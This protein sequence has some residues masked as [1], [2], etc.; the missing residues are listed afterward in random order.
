MAEIKIVGNVTSFNKVNRFRLNDI[1]LIGVQ[2]LSNTFNPKTDYIEYVIYDIAGNFIT[3]DYNY[4]NF[5]NTTT[6]GLNPN[7]SYSYLEINPE[8]DIQT[9]YNVG[10]FTTQYNFF[11][12]KIGNPQ[13]ADLFIKEISPDRTELKISTLQLSNLELQ[14]QVNNLIDDKN[15][16]PYLKSYLLN[17]RNNNNLLITNIALDTTNPNEYYVLF[18]LYSPLPLNISEKDK[19]WVVEEISNSLQFNLNIQA[20][21]IPDPLPQLKGPNFDIEI[22][23]K[24]TLPTQ[25]ESYSTLLQFTGSSLHAILNYLDQTSIDINVDYTDFTNFVRFGSAQ[26]RIENFYYK[27]KQIELYNNFINAN[28][29]GISTTTGLQQQLNSYSASVNDIISKFDGF[30]SYLYFQTGSNTYPHLNSI[31]P[32]TQYASTSTEALTWYT[33]QTNTAI[34]YDNNNQDNL[35]YLI[36]EYIRIDSDNVPYLTFVNMIGQYF[37][38]IYIYLKSVTDLYKS[39]N[40]LEEGVSKDLVYYA[41]Q[42]LGV[43]IYNSNED[44]NL[45]TYAIAVSGSNVPSK[46]LV[47]ELYKRIYHNIPLLF[48]GKGSRRGM[49]ELITTFGI[50]GSILGIKEY[51]GDTNTHASLVDYSNNKVRVVNN[52]IYSSSYNG[53][54]GSI[55]SPLIKLAT[56]NTYTDYKNDSDRVDI[57]FSPYNQ[58]DSTIS[59]SIAST[60]PTFNIDDFIGD[61]RNASQTEYGTLNSIRKT[62]IDSSFTFKYDINGFI[63]LIKFFDNTLFKML[64]SYIPAKANLNEGITIRQQALERIKFKRNE[65]N[66]AEQTVYDAEYSSPEIT[67]DNTY[68]YNNLAGNKAAF[69]TG[70]ISGSYINIGED[71]A[72]Q[73]NPYLFPTE[74]INKYEFNHTDY[75][76]LLNNIS[77]NRLSLDRLKIEVQPYTSSNLLLPVE[78]QDSY[79]SLTSYQLSRHGGIKLSSLKYNTYTPKSTTYAGDTSYGQSAVIDRYSEK[80]GLFTEI[81]TS[82]VFPTRL[83]ARLKYLVDKNGNLT[84]LNINNKHWTD[85]QNYFILNN[86]STV[87][88]FNDQQYSNQKSTNGLKPIFNSGYSYYPILYYSS[89]IDINLYFEYSSNASNLIFTAINTP[90]F[91]SSS[92]LVNYPIITGSIYNAF[93]NI[94]SN[95]GE[96]YKVGTASAQLF[97]SYSVPTTNAYIFNGSL[98][99]S[100]NQTSSLTTSVYIKLVS[101]STNLYTSSVDLVNR[102]TVNSK[103]GWVWYDTGTAPS[104]LSYFA[105]DTLNFDTYDEF[106]NLIASAGSTIYLYNLYGGYDTNNCIFTANDAFIAFTTSSINASSFWGSVSNWAAFGTAYCFGQTPKD[107]IYP[108]VTVYNLYSKTYNDTT[109]N[110]INFVTSPLYL[111]YGDKIAFQVSTSLA[112]NIKDLTLGEG[113]LGVTLDSKQGINIVSIDNNPNDKLHTFISPNTIKLKSSLTNL[114]NYT[115]Y[116]LT[117]S[118]PSTT[119]YNSL[120]SKYGEIEYPFNP[121]IGDIIRFPTSEQEYEFTIT[122]TTL[123][124]GSLYLTIAPN[125]ITSNV[126]G[127]GSIKEY[128]YLKRIE[129]ETNVI[130]NSKKRDGKTSYGFLLP[131]NLSP[132][133][134]NNIDTITKEIQQKLNLTQ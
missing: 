71:Y 11:Q 13:N 76:V 1:S 63:Q 83:N 111:N 14:N 115:F 54:T 48:K 45:D 130:L 128:V 56:D 110:T 4:N 134:L 41:L 101:G 52:T 26:K 21:I 123:S 119:G 27:I 106:G 72:T 82:S 127:T 33:T 20:Q 60:Y 75:N 51:G 46:D 78:L 6:N 19:F 23:V 92:L 70:E 55:L 15:N 28:N 31:T 85:I 104:S 50:T 25:Y 95:D 100:L 98:N 40:N 64:K 47:A 73:E 113:T 121:S 16:S 99:I 67:E 88:L 29:S 108:N 58:I 35:I 89:S 87:T 133:V 79:E 37:D 125:F 116:P 96:Y 80:I 86:N 66:V 124:G 8:E 114:L 117:G 2:T 122:N 30:E 126:F 44:D 17:F 62:A 32:Y 103:Q 97:P 5:K 36:P 39:Y 94:I 84:E 93:G 132:T 81:V 112:S 102:N 120:Y 49:Q 7:G 34:D 9:Y 22:N 43:N 69:Y 3:I 91:A 53:T 105:T 42:D 90:G 68:L 10:E 12:S 131:P 24:N 74:S 59:A 107:A 18:K 118:T 65:P 129:D 61:P 77:N 57:S 38:N 109:S